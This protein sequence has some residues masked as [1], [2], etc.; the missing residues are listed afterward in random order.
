[1]DNQEDQI[2]A[3]QVWCVPL[4]CPV[5]STVMGQSRTG[6]GLSRELMLML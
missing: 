1:M 6:P 3:R 5:R 4:V 2:V